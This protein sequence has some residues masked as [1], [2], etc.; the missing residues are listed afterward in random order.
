VKSALAAH[1][2]ARNMNELTQKRS[3]ILVNIVKSALA[4]RQLAS[5][6]NE[7]TLE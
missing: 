1:Q 4:T 6:M 7:L 5:D 3:R 2:I